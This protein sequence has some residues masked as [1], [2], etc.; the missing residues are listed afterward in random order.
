M[1][2]LV[3]TAMFLLGF[4]SYVNAGGINVGVSVTG[5][6]FDAAGSEVFSG[7]HSSNT[8]SGKVTKKSSAEGEDVET[9]F[10][11]GSLFIEA[12]LNDQ[13]AVGVDY[14]PT[15]LDSETTENVQKTGAYPGSDVTNKVD[16]SFDDMRTAYIKLTADVGAYFKI[17]YTEVDVTTNEVLGTGGKYGDTTLKGMMVGI[18]YNHDL[19]ND[20]FVRIEGNLMDFDDVSLTN[21]NDSNKTINANDIEG[22]GAR[23][24]VG[25][26]F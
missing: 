24:S 12:E 9:L 25:K 22:Y 6:V 5:G 7:D 1:K 16:V 15:G 21:I 11:F 17:G 19:P 18:G 3:Y 2:K 20:M 8:T 13:L 14:V 26:S 4:T 10:G 23:V